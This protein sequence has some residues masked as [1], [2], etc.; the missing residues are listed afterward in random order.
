MYHVFETR[1]FIG[2]LRAEGA[3]RAYDE[4]IFYRNVGQGLLL[5]LQPKQEV[6]MGSRTKTP[7]RKPILRC[8][9]PATQKSGSLERSPKSCSRS[10]PRP[11][12]VLCRE[13]LRVAVPPRAPPELLG[14]HS[15]ASSARAA[16]R[17]RR[18]AVS[19]ARAARPRPPPRRELRPSC[20]AAAPPR[21][22]PEL[23]ARGRRPVVSS[24]KAARLRPPPCRKHHFSVYRW[25]GLFLAA[26]F[27]CDWIL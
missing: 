3:G 18:P 24:A 4:S 22:P 8:V 21:A 13:L 11:A 20:W 12:R 2:L 9:P 14:R 26:I 15:V 1:E 16:P 17:G 25:R 6:F 7:I 27:W 10:R 23:L 19:T 5:I